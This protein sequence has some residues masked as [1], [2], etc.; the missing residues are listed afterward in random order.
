[1]GAAAQA[2][3]GAGAAPGRGVGIL[4][5]CFNPVHNGHLRL[6]IEVREQLDLARVE[7]MPA[8]V[9]PHK[10][11]EGMLPFA[12]RAALAEAAV[13]GVPG[14]AVSR[15][16]AERPGPSYTVDTLAALRAARPG[17]R[18]WFILGA[19]DLADLPGWHRWREIP[20]LCDLAVAGRGEAGP[21]AMAA[22]VAAHW[23]GA[24][25]DGAGGWLLPGGGRLRPVALQRLD[26]SASDVRARWLAGRSLAGLVPAAVERA[27]AQ[28]A[29]VV[30][31][32]WA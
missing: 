31:A 16:E 27:L 24:G 29:G 19:A 1:M 13:A 3:P 2:A 25:P 5:G 21:E 17:V 23:P 15:L 8:H 26:I 18:P 7:L 11:G 6:A 10:P 32:A 14:L 20:A 9:P 12:L 28:A 22:F 4:G 30:R